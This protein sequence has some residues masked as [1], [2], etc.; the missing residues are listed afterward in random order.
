MA[1]IRPQAHD[2]MDHHPFI[3]TRKSNEHEISKPKNTILP[4]NSYNYVAL[5]KGDE[6][7]CKPGKPHLIYCIRLLFFGATSVG[8]TWQ[9]HTSMTVS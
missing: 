8:K 1:K 9:N 2:P 5:K 6:K 3:M 7:S 4:Y